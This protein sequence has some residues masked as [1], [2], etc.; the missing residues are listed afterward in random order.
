MSTAVATSTDNAA[1]LSSLYAMSPGDIAEV[2][3]L[4]PGMTSEPMLLQVESTSEDSGA[5]FRG[6]LFGVFLFRQTLI[7]TTDGG[8]QWI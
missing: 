4:F 2:P 8:F 6:T 5:T 7:R 1:I 3:A